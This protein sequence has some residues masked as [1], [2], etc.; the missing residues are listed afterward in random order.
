MHNRRQTLAHLEC[1]VEEGFG[2]GLSRAQDTGTPNLK[3]EISYLK[4]K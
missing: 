2:A 4:S 1:R 3:P